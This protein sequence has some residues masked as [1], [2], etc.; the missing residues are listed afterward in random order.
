MTSVFSVGAVGKK[1]A[2][3]I[4]CNCFFSCLKYR[5]SF[6][7]VAAF[8]CQC[9]I[10][11]LKVGRHFILEYLFR[12]PGSAWSNRFGWITSQFLGRAEINGTRTQDFTSLIRL[13]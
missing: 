11:C 10:S 5:F 6:C 3:C 9:L 2:P 13:S 4:F 7:A 12:L 8:C 1:V